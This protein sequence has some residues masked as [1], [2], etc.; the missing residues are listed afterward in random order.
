MKVLLATMQFGRGYGQGTERYVHMLAEGLQRRG[1]EVVVLAG[2]PEHRGPPLAL[3]EE[4]EHSPRVL[5]YPTRGWTSIEGVPPA[6]LSLLLDREQPDIVHMVNPGHIGV[7][8]MS[9]ARNAGVPVVVTV[10]D[11]WWLCPRHILLHDQRGIC[12]ADVPW[13]ECVRCLGAADQRK[14]VRSLAATPVVRS[15]VLPILYLTRALSRGCTLGDCLNWTRRQSILLDA[16]DASAGIIFLSDGARRRIAPRL[17]H[18][19][20]YSIIV[21]M[22]D[23]WFQARRGGPWNGSPRDPASLTLGF[24]GALAEHKGTHLLLEAVARLGWTATR[25]RIA[26]GGT[27]AAYMARLHEL[28]AGLNVEFLGRVPSDGIPAL[29]AGLDLLIVPSTWPENLPQTVLEAQA[30]GTP[31]LASR[32]DGIAEVISDSTMLFDVCSAVN[33]AQCLSDWAKS[34]RNPPPAKPVTRADEMVASTLEVYT[35]LRRFPDQRHEGQSVP[36]P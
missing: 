23:R 27:D 5:F 28:A 25:V 30:V 24:V 6:R 18:R 34:P 19:R 11:Y 21:G 1:H 33:L 8:L 2:D 35:A 7:G 22:E 9:A 3:G 13:L 10:V 36:R 20:V 26:G 32:V 14:W 17:N 31:V 12:D 29:L 16:L 15:T 4:I